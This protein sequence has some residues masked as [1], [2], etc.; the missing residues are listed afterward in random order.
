M[1]RLGEPERDDRQVIRLRRRRTSARC[2]A[3]LGRFDE[4]ADRIIERAATDSFDDF[5]RKQVVEQAIAR[6]Q[7]RIAL[8]QLGRW[9]HFDSHL[10]GAN[11]VRNDVPSF[12]VD[13]RVS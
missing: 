1:N 10:V 13:V 4:R 6:Q 9:A 2:H 12:V 5:V 11:H 3:T 7:Q 8:G